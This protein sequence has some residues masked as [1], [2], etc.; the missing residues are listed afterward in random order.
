M[1]QAI[2]NCCVPL[3]PFYLLSHIYIEIH[4]LDSYT[5]DVLAYFSLVLEYLEL[6]HISLGV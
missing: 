2:I 6:I 4:V 1:D 3:Y 5:V